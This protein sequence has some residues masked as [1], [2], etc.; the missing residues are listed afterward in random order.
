M[1]RT[2]SRAISLEKH[3]KKEFRGP[4]ASSYRAWE[5]RKALLEKRAR[6]EANVKIFLLT[7]LGR[8]ERENIWLSVRTS[9][10]FSRPVLPL[11]Q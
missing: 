5:T 4:Y 7:D 6:N 8:A 1:I 11:S 2:T 10:I 9:Q 3:M